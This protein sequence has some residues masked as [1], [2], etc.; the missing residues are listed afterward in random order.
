MSQVR[1]FEE[2]MKESLA[3]ERGSC[4]ERLDRRLARARL[5]RGARS[6]ARDAQLRTE[7]AGWLEA[8]ITDLEHG[9]G[10]QQNPDQ[11]VVIR[12]LMRRKSKRETKAIW[13]EIRAGVLRRTNS[14]EELCEAATATATIPA[15]A[16]TALASTTL[17]R[18]R[19]RHNSEGN[20]A[21]VS[22]AAA[23]AGGLQCDEPGTDN[24]VY[25]NV[26]F[27]QG[28]AKFGD[29]RKNAA[30][31]MNSYHNCNADI[32]KFISHHSSR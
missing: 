30:I 23:A 13:S 15:P 9:R 6:E 5:E 25:E 14:V 21:E 18:A 8:I 27:F 31:E 24:N 20:Y 1:T 28:A 3:E 12:K 4:Q 2:T 11:E 32:H 26:T 7:I 17:A 22:A 16:S 10:E 29:K 19:V